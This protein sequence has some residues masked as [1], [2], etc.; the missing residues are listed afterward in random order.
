MGSAIS[1]AEWVDLTAY[2]Y[3]LRN[4]IKRGPDVLLERIVARLRTARGALFYDADF[5]F[6]L[7]AFLNI[8]VTDANVQQ[9]VS[10]V[11]TECEK[12]PRILRA[13]VVGTS[14]TRDQIDIQLE[15][16]T[17]DGPWAG[18]IRADSVEVSILDASASVRV[19]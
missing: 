19:A 15:L 9:M 5:G 10:G 4:N 3:G 18:V 8:R 11:E 6:D 7:R 12:D 16:E 17:T 2:P 14:I 1:E 13:Q